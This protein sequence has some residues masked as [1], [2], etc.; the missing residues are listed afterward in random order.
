[1]KEKRVNKTR[2]VLVTGLS[3]AGK[4]TALHTFEDMGYESIDNLPLA[5][6]PKL[7][8]L[9]DD[10][11][12]HP[13]GRPLAIGIDLRTRAF[14]PNRV[15][16]QIAM[17]R[18]NWKVDL[19]ILFMDCSDEELAKRFSETRRKHP[20]ALDRPIQDGIGYE[21]DLLASIKSLADVVL[22]STGFNIHETKRRIQSLYQWEGSSQLTI[23]CSSFSYG[24]GIPRSSDLVFDVR[25]LQNPHYDDDLKDKT[26]VDRGVGEYIEQDPNFAPFFDKINGLILSLLPLYQ[27]EGK[28]Y[29]TIAFGCTGGRHRSVF[30]AEKLG[31]LL[32]YSG[33]RVNIVHRELNIL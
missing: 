12:G 18:H 19:S 16:E 33:Y 2:V 26:G 10:T 23:V 20:M 25:F 31:N 14:Q 21:R 5:L 27:Q 11:P 29:L 22:D 15:V 30:T 24:K 28:S 6:M 3:G 4:T 8:K 13:E 7:L 32:E 17:L 9:E 1:M